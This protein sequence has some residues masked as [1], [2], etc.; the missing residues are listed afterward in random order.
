MFKKRL[1]NWMKGITKRNRLALQTCKCYDYCLELTTSKNIE[2][3][4]DEIFDVLLSSDVNWEISQGTRISYLGE[5][6]LFLLDKSISAKNKQHQKNLEIM[7][8]LILQISKEL[9]RSKHVPDIDKIIYFLH[10]I[11]STSAEDFGFD[12]D[13]DFDDEIDCDIFRSF[14]EIYNLFHVIINDWKRVQAISPLKT[15]NCLAFSFYYNLNAQLPIR[16]HEIVPI[17]YSFCDI[18]YGQKKI[19]QLYVLEPVSF[20]VVD[21]NHKGKVIVKI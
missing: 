4:V 8:K 15:W 1:I 7:L 13:D 10:T 12:F 9:I 20:V 11:A 16:D 14:N 2:N 19:E 5:I 6:T 18:V 3:L 17:A 21:K